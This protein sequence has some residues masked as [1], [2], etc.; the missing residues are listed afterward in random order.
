MEYSRL[1]VGIGFDTHQ[2]GADLD[3]ALVLGGI[4]FDGPGL[5]AHSDGDVLVHALLDS[6][7][8][9]SGLGD[10]GKMFSDTDPA[11]A[12]RSSAEFLEL[13]LDKFNSLGWKILNS[14]C[15]VIADRPKISPKVAEIQELLSNSLNSPVTVKGKRTEGVVHQTEAVSCYVTS[16]LLA[17]EDSQNV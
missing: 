1:R 9:P 16:L 17:P 2:I 4:T 6:L 14:D 15:V 10:I 8:G 13:V 12:N 7:L 3:K 11:N 5:V